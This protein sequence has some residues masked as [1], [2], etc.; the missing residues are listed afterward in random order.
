MVQ[1]R[2][3]DELLGETVSTIVPV[4]RMREYCPIEEFHGDQREGS[5]SESKKNALT[6]LL[7]ELHLE[8]VGKVMH[9]AKAP[10][11]KDTQGDIALLERLGMRTYKATAFLSFRDLCYKSSTRMKKRYLVFLWSSS[12]EGYAFLEYLPPTVVISRPHGQTQRAHNLLG[13]SE[14]AAANTNIRYRSR[15][16]QSRKHAEDNTDQHSNATGGMHDQATAARAAVAVKEE[17]HNLADPVPVFPKEEGPDICFDVICS[18]TLD[19][20][21]KN[22]PRVHTRVQAAD[23]E[24]TVGAVSGGRN[25]WLQARAH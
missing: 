13:T 24:L 18:R 12:G 10:K 15:V 23:G 20:Y 21:S 22:P 2:Q 3:S 17:C 4:S 1:L 6:K 19:I 25:L 7:N 9:A 16:E 8:Q 14:E 5:G 11:D